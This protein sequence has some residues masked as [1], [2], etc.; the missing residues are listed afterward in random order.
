MTTFCVRLLGVVLVASLAGAQT[1]TPWQEDFDNTAVYSPMQDPTQPSVKGWEQWDLGQNPGARIT[2]ARVLNRPH[3]LFIGGSTNVVQ[4]FAEDAGQ[5]V[6][7]APVYVS[8]QSPGK[9]LQKTH[10]IL[11][12]TYSHAGPKNWS[13]QLELDPAMGTIGFLAGPN[14]GL[15]RPLVTDEWAEIRVEIDLDADSAQVFYGSLGTTPDFGG[16]FTW[17]QGT[18]GNGA[19]RIAALNMR[20]GSQP[21]GSGV[22]YDDLFVFPRVDPE[23]WNRSMSDIA[24]SP[25]SGPGL[26][27]VTA[28][29]AVSA[30]ITNVLNDLSMDVE[31]R[32]NGQFLASTAITATI[33]LVRGDCGDKAPCNTGKCDEWEIDGLKEAGFCDETAGVCECKCTGDTQFSGLSI[34][35]GDLVEIVLTAASGTLIEFIVTD[36]SMSETYM[37]CEGVPYCTAKTGLACGT[38]SISASGVASASAS[39]GF[40]VSARPARSNRTAMLLY[41]NQGRANLPFPPGGHILCLPAT[42]LRRGGPTFS[43]GTPG[44]H[45]D[46]VFAVDM[47]AFAKGQWVPPGGGPSFNPAAYLSVMGQVINCQWWGRD[48]VAT[49]SFMSD[50][51]EYVVCP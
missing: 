39:A 24:F 50:A 14:A 46:G 23:H 1:N 10:F 26:V 29:W 19:S 45:C 5:W 9:L 44:P 28:H 25:G 4:R 20:A 40:V 2:T 6:V 30:G 21:P 16:A 41:S 47:N 49:G 48:T 34:V 51:L 43:G 18:G 17:S 12:N 33:Q 13:L 38:P 22:F 11:L 32:V 31:L 15:L 8:T 42:G 27:D 7:R 37:G 3:S 35:P 36:D